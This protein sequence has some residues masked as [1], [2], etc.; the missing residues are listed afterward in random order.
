MTSSGRLTSLTSLTSLAA[1]IALA[2]C[3][4]TTLPAGT[5]CQ[6]PADCDSGLSCLDLAQFTG[7]MCTVVGKSCSITCTIDSDC[8]NLGATYKC[9][10]GCGA[11][12]SCGNTAGSP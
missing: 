10:A 5:A 3:G 4:T 11:T 7:T 12:K 8:A 1:V 2:S 9:F 6:Q